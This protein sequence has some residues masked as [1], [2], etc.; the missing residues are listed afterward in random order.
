MMRP[1]PSSSATPALRSGPAPPPATSENSRREMPFSDASARMRSAIFTSMT[2]TM[3]HAASC[4]LRLPS[5]LPTP[6]M[7]ARS[8]AAGS[9]DIAPPRK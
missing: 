6:S 2:F 3:P 8:D 1:M 9:S 5:G 4:G 7:S